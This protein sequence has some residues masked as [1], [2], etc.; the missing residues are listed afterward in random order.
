MSSKE[1][2]RR[3]EPKPD[4]MHFHFQ[5]SGPGLTIHASPAPLELY[6]LPAVL[7]QSLRTERNVAPADDGS[8][9][10]NPSP[11]IPVGS[12]AQ[13]FHRAP[14]GNLNLNF[15]PCP[16]G[17]LFLYISCACIHP[18]Y[19]DS[20]LAVELIADDER[21]S[22]SPFKQG[23]YSSPAL[24]PGRYSFAIIGGSDSLTEVVVR[25]DRSGAFPP[26][27]QGF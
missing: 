22:L 21:I 4:Q 12:L 16:N 26:G 7:Q 14:W 23:K 8:H 15:E 1:Q 9:E 17:R 5:W 19:R 27:S 11:S 25:L 2:K 6:T 24:D 3:K 10:A 20:S 13:M 18:G